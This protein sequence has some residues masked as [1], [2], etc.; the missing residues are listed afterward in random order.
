MTPYEE[1]L[2]RPPLAVHSVFALVYRST[3]HSNF[4][5]HEVRCARDARNCENYSGRRRRQIHNHNHHPRA[6]GICTRVMSSRGPILRVAF[7]RQ[8]FVSHFSSN[9]IICAFMTST[10]SS[11]TRAFVHALRQISRLRL[12]H[13]RR[14]PNSKTDIPL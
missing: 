7:L 13:R 2:V 9:S 12:R 11:A 6:N 14:Y 8:T 1:V 5:L 3:F 4:S 10:F